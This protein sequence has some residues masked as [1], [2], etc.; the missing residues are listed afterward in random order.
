MPAPCTRRSPAGASAVANGATMTLRPGAPV[1]LLVAALL[2]VLPLATTAN[3]VINYMVFSMLIAL[4]A[5]GWNLLGGYAGQYSFGHAAFFGC[6]AY[7]MALLQLRIGVN[8]WV[9][10][11]AAA[12]IGAAVG[13][14][15]GMLAFRAGLRGSYFA[16]VTLAIAE[17]FRVLANA[18]NWTGGAA[19]LL[20]RLDERAGNFQFASRSVF[21]WIA[22]AL[23]TL[24]MLAVQ[25]LESS[26][27]GAQLVAVREN[28]A[29]ATALGIDVLRVKVLAITA[30]ATVTAVAGALY[31]QYF[32]FIDSTIAFGTWISVE[33]LLAAIIGGL[34]TVFGPLVGAL[35]LQ[36]L[37]ELTKSVAADVPGVDLVV[38]GAVLIVTVAFLPRGV[39]GLVQRIGVRRGGP[40]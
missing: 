40:R 39:M 3:T 14:V 1:I 17:V 28:E 12:V 23:V 32:L 2:A 22:L 10:F 27:L 31:T 11:G 5:L 20:I 8:P 25:R 37:S 36:G 15:V 6:G 30:S 33:A 34:G 9:A 38:F 16:L 21:Y 4:A 35:L 29:A 19:G 24:V 18:L 26:R 13:A 7:A